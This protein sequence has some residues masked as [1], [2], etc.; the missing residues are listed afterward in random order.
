MKGA[1]EAL[2]I[3]HSVLESMRE[4]YRRRRDL[5]VQGLSR[6]EGIRCRTPEGAYYVFPNMQG[7]MQRFGVANSS[8]LARVLLRGLGIATVPGLAF[9]VDG[10]LRLSYAVKESLIHEGLRRLQECRTLAA[11][12]SEG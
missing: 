6:V 8:D 12:G 9:G 5:M 7:F 2:S 11:I 1:V 3:P 4:E 10:H